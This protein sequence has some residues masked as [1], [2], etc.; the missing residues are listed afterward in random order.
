MRDMIKRIFILLVFGGLLGYVLFL[1]LQWAVIVQWEYSHLNG[2]F[3][4][5]L[6]I[7]ALYKFVFYGVYPVIVRF[8]KV[9]VFSLGVA[10]L[11]IGAYVLQDNPS[12]GVY[13]SD[14]IRVIGIVLM[15]LGPTN[16]L[17][18]EKNI[19]KKKLKEVEVIEV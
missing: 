1:Y 15:I 12:Q 6:F 19:T 7:F 3:Y 18:T 4:I 9:M 13:I 5:L 14:I 11:F 17:H 10:L 8:S 16:L 2:F